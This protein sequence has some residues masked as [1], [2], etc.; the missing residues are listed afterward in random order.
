MTTRKAIDCL[1]ILVFLFFTSSVAWAQ[2]TPTPASADPPALAP[3]A[4]PPPLPP[5]SD[6]HTDGTLT[7]GLA[8]HTAGEVTFLVHAEYLYLQ[9]RRRSADF[10]ILDPVSND[11][12]PQGS[13]E[14]LDLGSD[15]AFRVGGG[16][17]L[18]D[19]WEIIAL[20]TYFHSSE[21]RDLAAPTNGAL[22][23]TLTDPGDGNVLTPIS[24]ASGDSNLNYNVVDVEIA[25]TFSSS[26]G[27]TYRLAA[28]GRYARIAQ[29][30]QATYNG[31]GL[32]NDFV[33]SP[34][35]FDGLGIR[36]AAEARWAVWRGLGLYASAAGSLLA[37]DF[38]TAY[39][40]GD[41]SGGTV[42]ANV[43]ERFRKIV[44][45]AELGLG[46]GWQGETFRARLGYEITDWVGL[47][48]SPDFV[49]DV[50]NKLSHR[51]GDLSLDG[52]KF[53]VELDF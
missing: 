3:P 53:Q 46:I 15:S 39:F 52:V 42:I 23:P 17:R 40:E 37:G 28:G 27:L 36:A 18:A 9:P 49:S 25:N 24:T 50:T 21:H 2:G 30:L 44:P 4:W 26:H 34:I 22:Y 47:I 43:T 8:D 11:G 41:N 1:G 48:D 51:T 6:V 16:F 33:S 12:R 32:T 31:G 45:V 5:P 10:A 20:Y 35:R 13:V 38:R 14:S 7:E 19:G 29:N